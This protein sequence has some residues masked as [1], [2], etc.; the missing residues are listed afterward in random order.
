VL[1]AAA[2]GEGANT[3]EQR[4][5]AISKDALDSRWLVMGKGGALGALEADWRWREPSAAGR[6]W[7]D[8][9][10][11]ILDALIWSKTTAPPPAP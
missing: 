1:A 7:T 8:D 11:D 2:A 10:S 6:M 3:L 9:F 5:S 4:F